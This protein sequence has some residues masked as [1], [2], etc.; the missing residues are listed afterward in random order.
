MPLY[1]FPF[2]DPN[3]NI[4]ELDIPVNAVATALKDF[5]SKHLPP[6]LST[7]TMNKLTDAT[8]IQDHSCRLLEMRRLLTQLPT[9][10][11]EILK[12]VFHHFV[13]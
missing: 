4:V 10:N 3:C 12:F 6:L 13:K 8:A 7:Q 2:A 5:F 9:A 1:L 11:F